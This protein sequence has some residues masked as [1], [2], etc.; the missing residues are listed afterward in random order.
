L[1]IGHGTDIAREDDATALLRRM[2]R[3]HVMV[4]INLSSNAQILGVQGMDHPFM[5]YRTF[6]VPVALSTDDQGVSRIDLTHEY[7]RAVTTY[8]LSYETLK[9]LSRNSL[10]YAFLSGPSLWRSV[11]PYHA[12]AV[13]AD[14]LQ[15]PDCV[16]YLNA[17]AKARVQ[18]S[19]ETAYSVFEAS[20]TESN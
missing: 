12:V 14:D 18:A 10:E 15:A 1:R 13:C 19:L 3:E 17:S 7:V 8:H 9:E 16:A 5:T 6:G 2:A 4:E 11:A 20:M